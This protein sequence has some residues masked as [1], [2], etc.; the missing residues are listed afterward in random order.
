[1]DPVIADPAIADPVARL[2]ADALRRLRGHAAAG[3]RRRG[4]RGEEA[5]TRLSRTRRAAVFCIPR[6]PRLTGSG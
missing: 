1:M 2:P 5:L 4:P 3:R 6:S